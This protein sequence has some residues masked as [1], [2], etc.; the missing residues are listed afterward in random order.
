[1]FT[2]IDNF[3]RS[4]DSETKFTRGI[5]G[6]L[7]DESLGQAINNDHRNL[8]RIAW[9]IVTTVVDMCGEI[10]IKCDNISKDD[11][12]PR[13]AATIQRAYNDVSSRVMD[14]VTS[15]WSDE[16]LIEVDNLYG[17]EWEKGRTLA[18]LINHEIH[19]RGQ[20]TV[21]MRQ[22]GL[23]FPDLYGPTLEGWE[24]YGAKPPVV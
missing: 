23:T 20:M 11:P 4:Y 5:F 3:K 12:V 17:E 6:A 16:K 15:Q 9:H 2:S 18:I 19:H 1:M 13:D 21:L 24:K 7:T 22:A 10:G 8:G 14:H